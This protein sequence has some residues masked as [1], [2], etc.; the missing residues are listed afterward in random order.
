MVR[1]NYGTLV[2]LTE[3]KGRKNGKSF[4]KL[5]ISGMFPDEESRLVLGPPMFPDEQNQLVWGTKRF[6]APSL[7]ASR[8]LR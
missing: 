5:L 4:C 3:E 8:N 7:L 1:G 6:Q 2:G